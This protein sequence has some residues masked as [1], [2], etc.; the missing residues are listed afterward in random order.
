MGLADLLGVFEEVVGAVDGGGIWERI[1]VRSAERDFPRA[2]MKVSISNET[3]FWRVENDM[4]IILLL[5]IWIDVS[6]RI[7]WHV[8]DAIF[9][10]E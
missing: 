9:R 4:K 10:T 5:D 7:L 1:S 8:T 6:D 2:V 3:F